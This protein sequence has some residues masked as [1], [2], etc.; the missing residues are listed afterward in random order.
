MTGEEVEEEGGA[1]APAAAAPAM[2]ATPVVQQQPAAATAKSSRGV[3]GRAT[4]IASETNGKRASEQGQPALGVMS[5]GKL[6][7][8]ALDAHSPGGV[9]A[10]GSYGGP[11]SGSNGGAPALGSNGGAPASGSN[12]GEPARGNDS[13]GGHAIPGGQ[14]GAGAHAGAM[15]GSSRGTGKVSAG[16]LRLSAGPGVC[17]CVH[18]TYVRSQDP[19][20]C[21]KLHK[22]SD[23]MRLEGIVLLKYV[24]LSNHSEI[25]HV[26][27]RAWSESPPEDQKPV[28]K[29]A[30]RS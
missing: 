25:K 21:M 29:D 8:A 4:P 10:S 6:A 3:Q 23:Y 9:L 12:G 5:G 15:T 11:V 28:L 1:A 27:G 19:L 22:C 2:Q 7:R 18:G 17:M 24:V 14:A 13:D 30:P 20:C 16:K 26:S